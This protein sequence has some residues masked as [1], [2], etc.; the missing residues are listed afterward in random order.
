MEAAR[1]ASADYERCEL[2]ILAMRARAE[3]IGSAS[4][5][6]TGRASAPDRMERRVAALLDRQRALEG[7][8]TRDEDVM[9]AA[10]VLLFGEDDERRGGLAALVPEHWCEAVWWHYLQG[11][12]WEATGRV[13][14]YTPRY[15]MKI[16]AQA[17]EV[18][19]SYGLA[20]AASG[21]G[22]ACE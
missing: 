22:V 7:R 11:Q 19:D 14:G 17:F 15:L 5:G 4:S 6:P 2:Q 12:T 3:S 13:M 10:K 8:M 18:A 9:E 20:R 16:A 21:T 1:L